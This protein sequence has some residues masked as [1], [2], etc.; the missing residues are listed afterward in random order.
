MSRQ[1]EF[2]VLKQSHRFLRP[3]TEDNL[4]WDEQ[5]AAN[6]Y[7]SLY[8]EFALCNLKHYKSGQFA[9]RWRTED[10]VVS[11]TGETSC[12]NTRCSFHPPPPDEK[13][14]TRLSTL[15][16]PFAYHEHGEDHQALVKVVLC[17]SCVRKIMY[18]RNKDKDDEPRSSRQNR[19]RS[20][21]PTTTK[22][23]CT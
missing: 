1:S 10:E 20:K 4:S 6:Y 12:A 16:L 15:E 5:V 23:S 19:D 13:P 14:Q 2:D 18:K 17:D 11:G 9:L 7:N 22:P 21:S 3:E 8:R